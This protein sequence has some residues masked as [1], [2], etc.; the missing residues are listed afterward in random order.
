MSK[1]LKY[2]LLLI[3]LSSFL[4]AAAT[5][6]NK[7]PAT[8]PDESKPSTIEAKIERGQKIT[9]TLTMKEAIIAALKNSA[10]IKSAEYD[11][12][13]SDSTLL[14]SQSKYAWRALA[15]TEAQQSV[16]PFNQ[17]NI[18]TGTKSQ[19]NKLSAGIEKQFITGTYFKIE[20]SST[21]FDSNAFESAATTPAGF[22]ALGIPPLYTGAVTLTLSQDLLK[23]AFGVQDRNIESILENQAAMARE[24]TVFRLSS[25]V[26][27]TLVDY[28]N[29][30]I[31][32]TSMK[33]YEKLLE[34]TKNVRDL[35][36]SKQRIGLAEKFEINQWNALVAQA[37]NQLEK[38]KA[39]RDEAKRKFIRTLGISS[40]S[41]ISGITDILDD[42]P[43]EINFEKDLEYAL[44]HR[45]DFK[46]IQRRKKIAELTLS[47]AENEAL[48]SVKATGSY[49]SKGQTLISPQTNFTDKAE[50]AGSGKYQ[51]FTGQIKVTYSIADKGVKAGIRDGHIMIRQAAL[52]EED[53]KNE[54]KDDVRSRIDSMIAT[55]KILKSA[56]RTQKEAENYYSGILSSFRKGRFTAVAVKNALDTLVQDQLMLTQARINFNINVLRYDLSKNYLFEKFGIDVNKIIP[57]VN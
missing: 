54:V 25:L 23:N 31:A 33:T 28:W 44:Q 48:P 29:Y 15:G 21:R 38:T 27:Q 47:N 10:S 53:L 30:S 24:E 1:I 19:T 9:G 26:V 22:S 45:I 37:E 40:D 39:E 57:D 46:N 32:E 11:V 12:T 16:L 51:E 41:E 5:E 50:G 42:V 17:A 34:N 13:K 56:V 7:L 36:A 20:A 52:A 49:A 18:F 6:D 43:S 8:G 55:A 3:S 35:T 4:Y 14:K 2:N